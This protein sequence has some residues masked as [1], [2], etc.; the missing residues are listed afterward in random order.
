M[1]VNTVFTERKRL[2]LKRQFEEKEERESHDQ[3]LLEASWSSSP[4]SSSSRDDDDDE[5]R[6][7]QP[8][9]ELPLLVRVPAHKPLSSSAIQLR[10]RQVE[11]G[12]NTSAYRRYIATV[13]REQRTA[14]HPRTPPTHKPISRRQFDG[15]LRKWRRLLHAYDDATGDAVLR[16]PDDANEI[17]IDIFSLVEEWAEIERQLSEV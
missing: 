13:P 9:S 4:S 10:E 2:Q 3:P 11:V 15:Y 12:K 8:T 16:A 1:S 14:A 5:R 6:Q 17:E 7:Q